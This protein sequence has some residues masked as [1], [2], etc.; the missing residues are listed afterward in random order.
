MY[1]AKFSRGGYGVGTASDK[2]LALS[3]QWPLLPIEAE[4]TYSVAS[5]TQTYTIYN[6]G[7]DYVPV[8]MCWEESGGEIQTID[9]SYRNVYADTDDLIYDS[10]SDS[11]FTLHYKVFRRELLQTYLSGTLVSTDATEGDSSSYGLKVSLDTKDISSSGDRDF[12]VRSDLR[13]LMIHQS[14]YTTTAGYQGTATHNLG[15]KPMYWFYHENTDRNSTGQWSLVQ[16]TDDFAVSAS[17]T[18]LAW[19]LFSASLFN[20]AYLIFKDPINEVG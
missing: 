11:A 17:N 16:E 15:Y 5:G 18:Q 1:G 19:T 8:F 2:Q 3:S 10:W 20:W 7:L 12:S 14:G 4:G 9:A 13:Q 6:H